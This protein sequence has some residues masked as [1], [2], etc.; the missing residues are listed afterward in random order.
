MTHAYGG[1][2]LQKFRSTDLQIVMATQME[3]QKK[4]IFQNMTNSLKKE[5]PIVIWNSYLPESYISKPRK[6]VGKG[7]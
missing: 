5:D 7:S 2:T 6:L 1:I 4:W 3:V